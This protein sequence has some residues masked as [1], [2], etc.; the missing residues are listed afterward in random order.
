MYT[1]HFIYASA[2]VTPMFKSGALATST[3]EDFG[4]FVML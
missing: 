2:I 4:S 1:L 3:V